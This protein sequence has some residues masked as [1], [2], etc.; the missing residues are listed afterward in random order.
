MP[1]F[2]KKHSDCGVCC[3]IRSCH[4][5]HA[6]TLLV[7]E[8]TFFTLGESYPIQVQLDVVC[9][10]GVLEC[11]SYSSYIGEGKFSLLHVR[12]CCYFH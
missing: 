1:G 12:F 6:E 7:Q 11:I 8:E 4:S 2:P 9:D 5:K 3:V 10:F